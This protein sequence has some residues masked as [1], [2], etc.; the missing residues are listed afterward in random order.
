MIESTKQRF[1]QEQIR[2]RLCNR[3]CGHFHAYGAMK[4]PQQFWATTG[5]IRLTDGTKSVQGG[6]LRLNYVT[7]DEKGLDVFIHILKAGKV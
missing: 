5:T 3:A 4:L 1:E 6:E 7:I 2:Y